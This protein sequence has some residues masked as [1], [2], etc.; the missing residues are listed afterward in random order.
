MCSRGLNS[1]RTTGARAPE[2]PPSLAPLVVI[3]L[4][5]CNIV[6]GQTNN[7]LLLQSYLNSE[8]E[9]IE[10]EPCSNILIFGITVQG[11]KHINNCLTDGPILMIQWP[12]RNWTWSL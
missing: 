10:K 1:R 11:H 12:T 6:E 2:A 7:H 5:F 8:Q 4:C 3:I 9:K